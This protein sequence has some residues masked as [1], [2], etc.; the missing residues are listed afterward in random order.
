MEVPTKTPARTRTMT[1]R[2]IL[3]SFPLVTFALGFAQWLHAWSKPPSLRNAGV[4][5]QP[6]LGECRLLL[7]LD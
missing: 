4:S 6:Y 2:P 5:V 7:D 1:R 3:M